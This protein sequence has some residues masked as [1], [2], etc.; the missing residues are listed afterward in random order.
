M[1][2]WREAKDND[3]AMMETNTTATTIG[4]RRSVVFSGLVRLGLRARASGPSRAASQHQGLKIVSCRSSNSSADQVS[5]TQN[6]RRASLSPKH[7]IDPESTNL[8]RNYPELP[9]LPSLP[10][11][12]FTSK[13]SS[14]VDALLGPKSSDT[15]RCALASACSETSVSV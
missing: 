6:Q 1:T 11:K 7:I 13:P 4:N 8:T 15:P 10:V 3:D 5:D 2:K 12:L 14:Q 9:N